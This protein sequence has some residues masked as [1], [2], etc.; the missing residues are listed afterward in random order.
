MFIFYYLTKVF[1]VDDLVQLQGFDELEGVL[2][3][4]DPEV[5]VVLITKDA[6]FV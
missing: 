3:I 2:L 6:V 1:E 5:N 4:D